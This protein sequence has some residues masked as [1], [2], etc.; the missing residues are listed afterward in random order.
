VEGDQGVG[1]DV[2]V[3]VVGHD[4]RVVVVEVDVVGD[5]RIRF[6]RGV[7]GIHLYLR[8]IL[9]LQLKTKY[10]YNLF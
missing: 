10:K 6:L 4:R 3:V 8:R 1:E 5:R 7:L 2:D 9:L